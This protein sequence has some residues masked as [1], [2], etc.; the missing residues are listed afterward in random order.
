MNAESVVS[1]LK[2]VVRLDDGA[3]AE[4]C[5]GPSFI[6]HAPIH[7]ITVAVV[8]ERIGCG[9]DQVSYVLYIPEKDKNLGCGPLPKSKGKR[10][11]V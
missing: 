3:M 8:G 1:G 2:L 6:A 4:V 9:F 7:A 11:T 10:S 5:A